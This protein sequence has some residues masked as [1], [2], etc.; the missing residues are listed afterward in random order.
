MAIINKKSIADPQDICRLAVE[1]GVSNATAAVLINRGIDN[2]EIGRQFL[3][4]DD[5]ALNDPFEM[6]GMYEATALIDEAIEEEKRITIYGDYDVDGITST[7]ILYKYLK[8]IGAKVNCYIPNRFTEGY[9]MNMEAMSKIASKGTDIII[10]IDCG[11]TSV[12]EVALAKELGMDVMIVDH[13]NPPPVLPDADVI[14]NPKQIDCEYPFKELCSAGLAMKIVEAHGGKEAAAEYYDVAAIGTVADIV[15]LMNENRFFVKKGIEKINK[16]PCCGVKALKTVAGY[17]DKPINARGIAFGLAP[18]LNAAGRMSSAKDGLSMFLADDFRAAFD[19][20]MKL[21]EYNEE[22]RKI[23]HDIYAAGVTGFEAVEMCN[24]KINI[25]TGEGWNKGVIGIA[26]SRFVE[27]YHRP[28]IVISCSDDICT[29]SARSIPGFD[30]YDAL[31]QCKELYTKFGGHSQAAG[32]SLPRANIPEFVQRLEAY[33]DDHISEGMLIPTIDCETK[34]MPVDINIKT[35]KELALLEPYGKDN[36]APLFWADMLEFKNAVI[37]GKEKNV[38][39]TSLIAGGLTIDC[40]GFGKAEYI[41]IANCAAA[42]SAVFSVDLNQWQGVEKV[43]LALKELKLGIR[44][45]GDI[46]AVANTMAGRLFEAWDSGFV[47]DS[48]QSEAQSSIDEMFGEMAQHRM[49]SLVIVNDRASLERLL[50]LAVQNDFCDSMDIHIGTLPK[51]HEFGA[52][53]VLAMPYTDCVEKGEFARIFVSEYTDASKFTQVKNFTVYESHSPYSGLTKHDRN[54]FA[55][56]YKALH[57]LAPKLAQ[58]SM[59]SGVIEV[60]TGAT[61]MALSVFDMKLVLNVFSQLGFL[62]Y[63][64]ANGMVKVSFAGNIK[65]RQLTDSGMFNKYCGL[66]I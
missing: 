58:W 7:C 44:T 52:N 28:A 55:A 48:K 25:V 63:E 8:S 15:P 50:T 38:L 10:A 36:E 30:I 4:C 20:A 33:A 45:A 24:K 53:T 26:A 40:V 19:I 11:I 14:V 3:D 60:L 1:L 54:A 13:H 39:K 57:E 61:G 65:K 43:Q 23:E 62:T 34:L 47:C 59:L 29:A 35:A 9:G 16:S 32:F 56:M 31:C 42:K 37:I 18:R 6:L 41:D 12:N 2:E 66:M 5:S 21:N 64:E 22:R 51:G 27:Q 17:Q 46:E 49:G